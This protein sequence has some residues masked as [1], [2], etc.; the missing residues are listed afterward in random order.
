MV[1]REVNKQ[2][3]VCEGQRPLVNFGDKPEDA[4]AL[5][6]AIQRHHFDHLCRIG[7]GDGQPLTFLVRAR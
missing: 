5:L 2:W 1:V 4:R 6:Q 7:H 3:M